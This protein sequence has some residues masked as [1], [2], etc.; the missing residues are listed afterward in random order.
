MV[1]WVFTYTWLFASLDSLHRGKRYRQI[2]L[3]FV[4]AL[5][6]LFS[7]FL[8]TVILS[9]CLPVQHISR[10]WNRAGY[11]QQQ[12]AQNGNTHGTDIHIPLYIHTTPIQLVRGYSQTCPCCTS[13]TISSRAAIAARDQRDC[14][15]GKERERRKKTIF[16]V[17]VS[18]Y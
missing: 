6:L 9:V 13:C 14:R 16:N 3:C 18:V 2:K 7:L 1:H 8:S 4:G 15:K 5:L 12:L 10:S 11:D 17:F